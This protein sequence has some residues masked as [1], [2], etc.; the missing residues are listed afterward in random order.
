MPLLMLKDL[1]RFE[2]LLQA[3]ERFPTLDATASEAFLHLLRTGDDV[4]AAEASFLSRRGLS[5]GRFT[6]L[7]LLNRCCSEPSTPAE[8]AEAAAV[9]RATMTGLLDTLEKDGLVARATDPDDRRAVPVRLTEKGHA[10]MERILPEYFAHVSAI[11][12]PLSA[13]ER[14]QLVRLLQKI[15][16]GLESE[17]LP[18][19]ATA[20][21]A[22][23]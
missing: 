20:T 11:M 2:C 9:T 8:L 17:S 10:L 3:V 13:A 16:Q 7:M 1:P 6:V 15:Q 18:A 19:P 4:Y 22:H 5:Q 23:S 14:K 21:P 12:A